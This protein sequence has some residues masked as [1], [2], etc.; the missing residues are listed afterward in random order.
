M[1]LRIKVKEQAL[2]QIAASVVTAKRNEV[3]HVQKTISGVYL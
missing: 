3:F 2:P 1:E